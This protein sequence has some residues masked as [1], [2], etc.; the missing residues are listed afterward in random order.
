MALRWL[1]RGPVGAAVMLLALASAL[2]AHA[3]D[4][5]EGGPTL[6]R[7]IEMPPEQAED[8]AAPPAAEPE[9]APPEAAPPEAQ[10]TARTATEERRV[11]VISVAMSEGL[12]AVAQRAGAAARATL[13]G[14]EG[15]DWRHAD[16]LFLGYDESA[17]EVL[18]RA[19]QRLDAGR[20]AYLNLEL[21]QAIEQLTGAVS[22]FDAAAAAVEDPHD[23]GEAL[24]FLGASLA[25]EGRA[26]DAAR[27]FG[28]LHVQMPHVRP[29]PNLFNPD[30]IARFE[31]AQPRDGANP[32]STIRI[33]SDPPGAIAYV[34]FLAR[35]VTPIDV[36]G[37]LG[38][39]HIVRVTR[40]GATPYVQ[41]ITVRPRGT[42][43][44]SAY[45]VDDDRTAGLSDVLARVPQDDVASLQTDGA[46]RE[47]AQRLDV[48]RIGVIRVSPGDSDDRAALELLVFDVASGRRLVR[49]A[50]TVPTGVGDLERGVDQLVSGAL[51][52]ALTARQQSDA[53]RIPARGDE[54]PPVTT[55]PPSEPS[56]FEQ[57]W[58]WA[59]VGGAAV[60]V[61]ASIAIGVAASDQGPGLGNDPQGYV[62][63][64]F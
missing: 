62:V 54:P 11:Y 56:V 58:F 6:P 42:E 43:S 36:G 10:P 28:R 50:G 61:G 17:L 59:I 30:V 52:A 33:E 44:T 18:A 37:L 21:P 34:D 32:A 29:D 64:E 53:E 9:A 1:P 8:E 4:E 60:V 7:R 13:R 63:L 16:R 25:F 23:L 26:R 38:G 3:Q 39:E 49:G 19:R 31:A 2:P 22:D 48:E 47:I 20:Q 51:Q 46:I 15:V 24:L 27:V 57:W 45:L 35:G 12:D 55:P 41:S 5:D 40:A 14:I